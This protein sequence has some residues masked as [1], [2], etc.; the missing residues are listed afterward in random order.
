MNSRKNVFFIV[1]EVRIRPTVSFAG[2][3]LSGM[4][5]N[6]PTEKATS[7]LGVFMKCMHGGPSLM[8]SGT[9]VQKLTAKFQYD[10]VIEMAI[11]VEKCGGIVLGSINDNHKVNQSFCTL[12]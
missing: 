1:D 9:P 5:I 12:F 3:M 6:E 2:G 7:M 11:K 8:I 10:T 4:T